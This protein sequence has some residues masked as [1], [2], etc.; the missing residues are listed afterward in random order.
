MIT[1]FPRLVY[2]SAD[3]HRV[4]SNQEEFDTLR[5]DGW[6]VSVPEALHGEHEV[7]EI[8]E[9][10]EI[11]EDMNPDIDDIDIQEKRPRGRPAKKVWM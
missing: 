9:V 5:K 2:K 4:A 7:T 11:T 8:A 3:E 6:F 1:E 10:V